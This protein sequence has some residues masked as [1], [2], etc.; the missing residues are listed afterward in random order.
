MHWPY[1]ADEVLA[2]VLASVRPKGGLALLTGLEPY[3]LALDPTNNPSD[4]LVF[5]TETIGDAAALLA[6]RRTYRELP[7][8]WVLRHAKRLGLGFR[9]VATKQ[10]E[11]TLSKGYFESQLKF[12]RNEAAHVREP[13]VRLGD[14]LC[15]EHAK[16]FELF[17]LSGTRQ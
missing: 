13:P 8:E 11:T 10:F 2:R 3:D 16:S 1:H 6:R 7:M 14:G 15:V 9:V 5:D 17:G 4:G 12:A